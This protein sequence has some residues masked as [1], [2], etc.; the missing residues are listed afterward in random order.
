MDRPW[1]KFYE[2]GVPADIEYPEGML[3]HHILEHSADRFPN[4][5]A[6]IFPS[7]VGHNLLAGRLTYRDVERAANRFANALI[8]LG[9]QK[10]DRVALLLP[11]SP[12]FLIAY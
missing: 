12:Q 10:G 3:V 6:T 11:N 5:P 9:I 4:R 1:L 2:P 7:A 8:G